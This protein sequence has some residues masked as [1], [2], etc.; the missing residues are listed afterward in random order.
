MSMTKIDEA[1]A[2]AVFWGTLIPIMFFSIVGFG[3]RGCPQWNVYKSG[4]SGEAKLKEAYSSRKVSIEEAKAKHESAKSLA[5]AEV[6]RAK[7][8]ARANEIIGKS[9][10]N[11]ESYLRYLWIQGLSDGNSETIYVPTEANLPILEANRKRR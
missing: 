10:R 5:A 3:L 9:L 2:W 1:N 8:V 6:E 7:G 11:N 4:L